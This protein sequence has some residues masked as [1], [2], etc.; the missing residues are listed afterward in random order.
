MSTRYHAAKRQREKRDRLV[1][2]IQFAMAAIAAI[3]ML[4]LLVGALSHMLTSR[5]MLLP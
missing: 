2:F 4:I 3:S 5:P 1:S